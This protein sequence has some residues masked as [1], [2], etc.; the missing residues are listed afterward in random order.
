[1]SLVVQLAMYPLNAERGVAL[2]DQPCLFAGA[3]QVRWK[4]VGM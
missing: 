4:V 2:V 3:Q 1:M